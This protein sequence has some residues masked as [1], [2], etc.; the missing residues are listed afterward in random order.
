MPDPL[1]SPSAAKEHLWYLRYNSHDGKAHGA[2]R[3]CPAY[4]LR[5]E[6]HSLSDGVYLEHTAALGE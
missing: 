2:G 4:A 1:E 6:N 5:T 3:S